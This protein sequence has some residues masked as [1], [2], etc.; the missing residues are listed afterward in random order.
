MSTG[1]KKILK[2]A[3]LATAPVFFGYIFVGMAFGLLLQKAGYNFIWAFFCSLIVYAGSMQF[4][5][6]SLLTSGVGLVQ[7]AIVTLVV[8][9]RH[10]F[11]GLSLIEK[12]K[13]L[14]KRKP[15]MIFALT[16]ETY[17]LLCSVK[18]PEGVSRENFYFLITLLNHLYWIAGGVIGATIGELVT[19]NSTGIEFAMTAL[20]IV[21]FTEQWLTAES[22]I[23]ALVGLGCAMV[24][25]L[26][27]GTEGFLPPALLLTVLTLL[28]GRRQI[29]VKM[30]T[31]TEQEGAE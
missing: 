26:L 5:L 21:I 25:L 29:E 20:F 15:Y 16:D 4:I 8:Q 6:V 18:S 1:F 22:H 31:L 12:F 11:Y 19:F 28:L 2:A 17:S 3:V 14:G 7:V 10:A 24:C 13:S 23:P 9:I 27:F 30:T